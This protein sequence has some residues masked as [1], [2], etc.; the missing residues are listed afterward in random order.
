MTWY[1][2]SPDKIVN[3]DKYIE[4]CKVRTDDGKFFLVF[5]DPTN[6]DEFEQTMLCENEEDLQQEYEHI[7]EV[8]GALK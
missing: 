2:I 4:I 7:C 1:R 3:L 8:T 5:T 6:N